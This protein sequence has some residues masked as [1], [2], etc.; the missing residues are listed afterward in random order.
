M[1][2]ETDLGVPPA[3]P[4]TVNRTAQQIQVVSGN[5]ALFA[6]DTSAVR[7]GVLDQ[8]RFQ[9]AEPQVPVLR[10]AVTLAEPRRMYTS[11]PPTAQTVVLE[12]DRTD[13]PL[14]LLTLAMEDDVPAAEPAAF[15]NGLLLPTRG[16]RVQLL[17]LQ[18]G[19]PLAHAFQPP[20]PAGAEVKWQ[21]PAITPDGQQAVLIDGSGILFRLQLKSDP[22]P[23]LAAALQV[24]TTAVPLAAPLIL[25]STVYVAVRGAGNDQVLAF[26]LDDFQAGHQWELPGRLVWGPYRAGG[27]VLVATDSDQLWALGPQPE[28]HWKVNLPH[29]RLVGEPWTSD[30]ELVLAFVRGTIW[31][32]SPQT[33]EELARVE[34]DEPIGSGPVQFAGSR[35]LVCG[36][37]G[38][39]QV[40]NLPSR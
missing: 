10:R 32:I 37:D 30:P 38:T 19:R 17:D 23:N 18:T 16:G 15:Q 14:R 35:M 39:V 31:Q 9:L 5:A 33:G 13:A 29:G 36:D 3:G 21:A 27:M 6:V 28:P 4:P 24:Q 12:P 26:S 25:D 7:A 34:L 2:W 22:Q 40:V 11:L 8:P 1:I 20:L